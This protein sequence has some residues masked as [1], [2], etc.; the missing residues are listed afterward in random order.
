MEANQTE[1]LGIH[2]V[3]I[4]ATKIGFIFRELP[5][6]DQ[7]IDG[8]LETTDGSGTAS[9]RL[10]AVQIKAGL[11][12]FKEE[13]ENSF[14]FR[15]EDKHRNLWTNHSLPVIVILCHP[16]SERCY[17]ELVTQETCRS[18]GKGWRI[19]I[20]KT[21]ALESAQQLQDIA[22]PVAAASD[23][24]VAKIDDVSTG[25]A[26]R[27]SLDVVVH[28]TFKALSKIQLASIVRMVAAFGRNSDYA[29]DE[30]SAAAHRGKQADMVSGFIYLREVDRQTA[31]WVCRFQW[32]SDTIAEEVRYRGVPGQV[33]SDGLVIDWQLE[34]P[35]AKFLDERRRSKGDYLRLFDD[36]VAKVPAISRKL[37]AFH[38]DGC[39]IKDA[40]TIAELGLDFEETWDDSKSPPA[41]C[42]RLDQAV[43][44]MLALVG[45]LRFLWSKDSKY[46]RANAEWQSRK[47][48]AGLNRVMADINFLRREAR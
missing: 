28:P 20:P 33:D 42:V 8:Q 31:Q 48:E 13:T 14:V 38:A 26:R 11:S 22:S 40:P 9:G 35:L 41:E 24:T 15:P 23:F 5:T 1:R 7:G 39:P 27:L 16:S 34:R 18:T 6:S 32:T 29:R 46:S 25:L 43:G 36:L 19:D 4:A 12:W 17:W 10:L 37:E 47:I 44:E 45:N 30:I 2:L 3:G 21:Q